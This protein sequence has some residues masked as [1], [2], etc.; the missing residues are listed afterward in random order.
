M[1]GHMF[2]SG[3]DAGLDEAQ[4]AAATHGDGPL[5]VLAGAGTGKTRTLVARVA[6]LIDRGVDPGRVLLLT[7][8]RRAAEDMLARAAAIGGARSAVS[9]LWVGTFHAVAQKL[10]STHAQTLGLAPD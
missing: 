8:P 6:Q 3:W 9:R 2:D 1:V 7:F 5:V 10:V 4:L